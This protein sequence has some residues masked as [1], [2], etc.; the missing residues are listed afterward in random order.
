MKAFRFLLNF[1][2]KSWCFVSQVLLK[3]GIIVICFCIKFGGFMKTKSS[4]LYFIYLN[5]NIHIFTI[6]SKILTQCNC[7]P[8]IFTVNIVKIIA[9]YYH[10]N[11]HF[12]QPTRK[13]GVTFWRINVFPVAE[14]PTV[15]GIH[16]NRTL[17]AIQYTRIIYYV[18]SLVYRF[19]FISLSETLFF[20][21]LTLRSKES[22]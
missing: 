4:V 17:P 20:K 18:Y 11:M 16:Q 10:A 7:I 14:I 1:P 3:L 13:N 21:Y 9:E 15:A 22:K 8:A 12:Y 6:P 2:T 5:T 19:S